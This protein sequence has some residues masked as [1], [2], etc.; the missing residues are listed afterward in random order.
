M[1]QLTKRQIKK[2]ES[3]LLQLEWATIK[4]IVITHRYCGIETAIVLELKDK[5]K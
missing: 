5:N 4:D 1:E 3:L 2:I